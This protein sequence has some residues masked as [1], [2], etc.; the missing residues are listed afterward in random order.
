M[1]KTI[2]EEAAEREFGPA[3]NAAE[4]LAKWDSG[5]SIWSIEMGGLGP[6][7]EQAIQVSAIEIVRDNLD[8][9][10]P[11]QLPS[12]WGEETLRR[13]D[14]PDN[15]LGLSGAQWGAAKTLAYHWLKEGPASIMKQVNKDRHI[16]VSKSWP[17]L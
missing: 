14:Q 13:I 8:R 7:Y 9:P 16:Q 2:R 4:Q 10:L 5:K 11:K 3:T 17:H 15:N 12:D 6:G 1:S